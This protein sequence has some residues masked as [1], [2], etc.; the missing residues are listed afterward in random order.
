MVAGGG[1]G[2]RNYDFRSL[3]RKPDNKREGE[4]TRNRECQPETEI[5]TLL[6]PQPQIRAVP[7]R[8]SGDQ[9]LLPAWLLFP[10]AR[11]RR[12][13]FVGDARQSQGGNKWRWRLNASLGVCRV[14]VTAGR[15]SSGRKGFSIGFSW[16]NAWLTGF[17][18]RFHPPIIWVSRN[19]KY[20]LSTPH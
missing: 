13:E 9:K 1:A 17:T 2:G 6:L 10:A 7:P 19:D 3:N 14:C 11:T 5:A 8:F 20:P 15:K 18:S 12:E 4:L 16:S